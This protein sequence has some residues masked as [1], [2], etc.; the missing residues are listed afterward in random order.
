MTIRYEGGLE[1]TLVFLSGL[2]VTVSEQDL[3]DF[4]ESIFDEDLAD[5][6]ALLDRYESSKIALAKVRK[7]NRKLRRIVNKKREE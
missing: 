1:Y 7:A 2:E 3:D 4:R 5:C 6:E